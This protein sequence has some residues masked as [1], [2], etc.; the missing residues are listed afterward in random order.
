M[1]YTIK[2][3]RNDFP[4]DEACLD[5]IFKGW[6]DFFKSFIKEFFMRQM[7]NIK[8]LNQLVEKVQLPIL[9]A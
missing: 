6:A 8:R 3:L 9:I 7:Y 4:N 1:K 2:N 5:F